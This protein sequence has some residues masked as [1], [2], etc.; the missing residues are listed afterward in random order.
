MAEALGIASG[1]AGIVS[2]GLEITQGLLKYYAA[3]RDQ[4]KD[5]KAMYESLTILEFAITAAAQ[6]SDTGHN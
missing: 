2:L 5:I 1:A 6:T 3:W 4:D